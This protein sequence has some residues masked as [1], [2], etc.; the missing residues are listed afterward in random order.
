M[1]KIITVDFGSTFTKAAVFDLDAAQIIFT[2]KTPSTVNTNAILGLDICYDKIKSQIGIKEFNKAQKLATSSAAGGL[3]MVVVGLTKTLSETAG[4]N[5]AFGAGAKILKS[6]VGALDD[7]DIF[8]IESMKVEIILFCGGY[9]GGNTKVVRH[10]AK[11]LASMHLDNK[12]PIIYAGNTSLIPELKLLFHQRHK[13]IYVTN[14]IIPNVGLLNSKPVEALI[15]DI[16]FNRITNMKGLDKIKQEIDAMIIPTPASVLQAGEL[17]SLGCDEELGLG[18]IMIVDIGG[19]TTDVHSYGISTSVDGAKIIGVEEPYSKRTVEGDLGMR[20]SCALTVDAIGISNVALDLDITESLVESAIEKRLKDI[21][22]LPKNDLESYKAEVAFDNQVAKYA[23]R[24]AARRHAGKV[25]VI[26][27]KLCSQ[28]QHGKNLMP[29]KTIIGT[30]G[31][32]I[33]SD[34]PKSIL[35]EALKTKKDDKLRILLPENAKMMIDADYVIYAAG[36]LRN[37]D[38]KA[39]IKIMKKSLKIV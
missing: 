30:G 15:R 16:F 36:I 38:P 31:P 27:S 26:H 14:N 2:T 5:A 32:I 6:Y 13:E 28:L 39:A 18:P 25:E 7:S 4:K 33:N 9:E 23:C 22:F 12:I 24:I 3:R 17:L 20:E 29:I 35:K 19:A 37:I 11:M 21:D 1:S 10:N 8:E 34:N